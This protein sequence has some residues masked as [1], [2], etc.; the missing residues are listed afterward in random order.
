MPLSGFVKYDF[1][2]ALYIF[3]IWKKNQNVDFEKIN[4]LN[5][6]NVCLSIYFLVYISQHCSYELELKL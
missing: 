4:V 1:C 3:E 5:V 6:K 2:E